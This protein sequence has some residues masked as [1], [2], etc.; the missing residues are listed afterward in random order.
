M[1]TNENQ[2]KSK[3]RGKKVQPG[4]QVATNRAMHCRMEL[5]TN[6][7]GEY[8]PVVDRIPQPTLIR[9]EYHPIGNV[10]HYPKQWGRKYAATKLLEHK[11]K[12]QRDILATATDELAKL[13]KCLESIQGWSETDE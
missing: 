9:G 12:V 6:P 11:I 5:Y 1:H 2:N 4:E 10:F 7:Q 13:E 3:G 8:Y